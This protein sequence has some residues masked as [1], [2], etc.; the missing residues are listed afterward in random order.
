MALIV[1]DRVKETSTTTGTGT[2]TLA[3]AAVGFETFSASIGNTNTT[4]YAIV[5]GAEF[6]VGLGTVAA[7]T[8]ARTTV[9]QSSNADA[10]VNFSAG[11][12]DVFCTYPAD[13]AVYFN[14]TNKIAITGGAIWE[15][16][17]TIA[18]NYTITTNTNAFS[19]GTVT[20]NPTFTVTVPSG[21][22]WVILQE[23]IMAKNK[24]S[25][26]SATAA[27]N[28][29]VGGI[30][31]AEG[32]LPSDVNNAIRELMAQL[33]DQQTGAD[34]DN[35]TVGGNLSVTGTA[36]ITGNL[37]LVNLTTTG[38]TTLGNG[39]GDTLTITGSAASIP[40]KL[41]LDNAVA[42]TRSNFSVTGAIAATTLTVTVVGT[43]TI[44]VGMLISGTGVTAA[45]TITAF[46][47]GTG[48]TGTYTV[49]ISQTVSS[50]TITGITQDATLEIN[51][52]DAIKVAVG[53]T[54]QRPVGVAGQIRYNTTLGRF[55]AY[56]AT[57]WGAIGGGAT[58]G[59]ADEVFVENSQT[60]TTDYTITAG[61]SA[62]SV[63][64]VTIN[65]S[66]TVTVPS[67]SRW[68]VL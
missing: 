6:E 4:Y 41:N 20:I 43:G 27:S 54:A 53:T 25:E 49:S 19:V 11:T 55:E 57:A 32:M 58:G 10:L 59:G 17:N 29:D 24:I 8:L 47:T 15:N 67:G 3:G 30:N 2:L 52:T 63:G 39:S 61:K 46:G 45:T 37:S 13:V 31:L 34:L 23:Q 48:G 51:S 9:L 40:N 33:K 68:V 56:N 62:S 38:N 28:T 14:A 18:A 7:G 35:F 50:T 44:R 16:T 64:D 42:I 21:S 60:V 1:K 36:T 65:S 12:K 22:R 66:V 26:Y 5:G